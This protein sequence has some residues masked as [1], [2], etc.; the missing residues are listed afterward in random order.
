MAAWDVTAEGFDVV[1]VGERR[2]EVS[3]Y[4]SPRTLQIPRV[5][6]VDVTQTVE[7]RSGKDWRMQNCICLFTDR[8][9][10]FRSASS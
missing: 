6:G 3:H 9:N 4:I 8:C 7:R 1:T 2:L 10:C 5:P